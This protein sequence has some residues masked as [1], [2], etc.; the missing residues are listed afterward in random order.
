M[1]GRPPSQ[2]LCMPKNDRPLLVSI[3]C[4]V[5]FSP[6][7]CVTDVWKP[8]WNR[9]VE[10]SASRYTRVRCLEHKLPL[11]WQCCPLVTALYIY[12]TAF[13][14]TSVLCSHYIYFTMLNQWYFKE[15]E[16]RIQFE[17][18]WT[19]PFFCY[20]PICIWKPQSSETNLSF[21]PT[22]HLYWGWPHGP[23]RAQ[24]EGHQ[25][26]LQEVQGE[27]AVQETGGHTGGPVPLTYNLWPI[28]PDLSAVWK[29][30]VWLSPHRT[31]FWYNLLHVTLD[32]TLPLSTFM[33]YDMT[34]NKYKN[35]NVR[36]VLLF[37]VPYMIIYSPPCYLSLVEVVLCSQR[38]TV[39]RS[40]E[41]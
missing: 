8:P 20:I 7:C 10:H 21:H 33:C 35:L 5:F 31:E 40:L 32:S 27:C 24:D 37:I 13:V 41:I 30:G 36:E 22:G 19:G 2:A 34:D 12:N 18:V 23:E 4:C 39:W 25:R 16:T 14:L 15:M 28:T 17:T 38:L 6:E 26:R 9:T 11:T 29:R 3:E 1:W